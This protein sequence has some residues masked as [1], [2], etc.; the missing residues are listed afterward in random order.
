VGRLREIRRENLVS[1]R[2]VQEMREDGT[3]HYLDL[4]LG[5]SLDK[6]SVIQFCLK[7][8]EIE[9]PWF[10]IRKVIERVYQSQILDF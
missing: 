3:R 9:N 10:Q 7:T 1:L 5:P 6:H 8:G 2:A 4:R